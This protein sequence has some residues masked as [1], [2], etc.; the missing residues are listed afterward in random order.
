MVVGIIMII[1]T[2]IKIFGVYDFSS[3]WFWFLAGVGLLFQGAMY[4]LKQRK[5]ERKYRIIER[6]DK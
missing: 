3:D 4:L 2:L 6:E 5:F 1:A